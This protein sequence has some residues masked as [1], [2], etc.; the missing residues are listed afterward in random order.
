[1]VSKHLIALKSIGFGKIFRSISCLQHNE[2]TPK[3]CI[4]RGFE[5][6]CFAIQN[7]L[8]FD[9]DFDYHY[10]TYA[11]IVFKIVLFHSVRM[12]TLRQI[13]IL[14]VHFTLLK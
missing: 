1:M 12:T 9:V 14:F 13:A 11:D 8:D 10:V 2:K 4:Y 3:V 5:L 7:T 6:E